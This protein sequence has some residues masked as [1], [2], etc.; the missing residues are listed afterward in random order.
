M[1]KRGL[2]SFVIF[3]CLNLYSYDLKESNNYQTEHFNIF[4]GDNYPL[5]YNWLI[6][7]D[8]LIPKYI[9]NLSI[10]L[11]Q[12]YYIYNTQE[13]F[14]I[15]EKIDILILD[16][17]LNSDD[18]KLNSL[19]EFGSFMIL[20]KPI[21]T[22]NSS[23]I[24][25]KSYMKM[26]ASHELMHAVQY[27]YNLFDKDN[28]IPSGK[29]YLFEGVAVAAEKIYTDNNSIYDYYLDGLM[30]AKYGEFLDNEDLAYSSGIFI[31]YLLK[32]NYISFIDLL[33]KDFDFSIYK[34]S[35]IIDNFYNSFITNPEIY[36][37]NPTEEYITIQED[38]QM[39]SFAFDIDNF[40]YFGENIQIWQY[41]DGKWYFYSDDEELSKQ[42]QK[43][44][45]YKLDYIYSKDSF[46]IYSNSIHNLLIKSSKDKKTKKYIKSKWNMLGNIFN[47]NIK[48]KYHDRL[49]WYFDNNKLMWE[50]NI[51]NDCKLKS[52]QGFWITD[53]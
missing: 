36:D 40:D 32:N 23:I 13:N 24:K 39:L 31:Y 38:W 48:S 18:L 17:G 4:W 1:I 42:V 5:T 9:D 51:K 29:K 50:N 6:K 34:N 45:I 26:I 25:T 10:E 2:A 7:T 46:W 27:S 53:I 35:N 8:N 19:S 28:N 49:I 33:N 41:T 37:Y 11:E 21:L 16:T 47:S 22:I 20:D 12:I 52:N 43:Y 3:F 30:D 14:L 44:G 15:P